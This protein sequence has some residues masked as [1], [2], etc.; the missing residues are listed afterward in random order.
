M[1]KPCDEE[2]LSETFHSFYDSYIVV[3][4]LDKKENPEKEY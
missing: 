4:V 3:A 2:I 1:W